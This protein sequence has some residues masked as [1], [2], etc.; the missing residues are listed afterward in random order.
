MTEL[1]GL[2]RAGNPSN[3]VKVDFRGISPMANS[4]CDEPETVIHV[5]CPEKWSLSA[6]DIGA[7]PFKIL[8]VWG[9]A[10][11]K[12]ESRCRSTTRP[13]RKRRMAKPSGGRV[14]GGAR[15]R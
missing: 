13:R 6:L 9:Q 5:R 3:P 8:G 11:S 7:M 2:E 14:A 10:P 12:V 1:I 15:V 4:A